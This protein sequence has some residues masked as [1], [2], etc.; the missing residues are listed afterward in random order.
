MEQ[1]GEGG[2]NAL[3]VTWRDAGRE[4]QCQPNPDYPEGIA[5][6]LAEGATLSCQTP[7]PYPARRCGAYIVDCRMCGLRVGVT[8]AGRPDD[9]VSLKVACKRMA[10]A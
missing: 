3:S 6:D 8:T 1:A 9:P 5:I 10:S 7:L 2:M 4:P